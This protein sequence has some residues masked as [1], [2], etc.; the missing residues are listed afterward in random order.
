[1]RYKVLLLYSQR[2]LAEDA[3]AETAFRVAQ[4]CSSSRGCRDLLPLVDIDYRALTRYTTYTDSAMRG[5]AGF[6]M[7]VRLSGSL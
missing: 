1:M 3:R 5:L 7:D 4:S 6:E 2:P